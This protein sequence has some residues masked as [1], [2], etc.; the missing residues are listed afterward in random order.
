MKI[1][2][3]GEM[4]LYE[5]RQC[6]FEQLLEVED[7]FAVRHS[8]DATVYINPTNGFGDQVS[9]R[10]ARGEEVST[11]VSDGPYKAAADHYGL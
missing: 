10:D 5:L 3:K 1:R 7:Q 2:I 4:T 11:L 8:R 9:C 6:I